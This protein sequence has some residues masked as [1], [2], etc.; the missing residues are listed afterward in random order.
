[1]AWVAPVLS[2]VGSLVGAFGAIQAGRT[3]NKAARFES[4]VLEQQSAREEQNAAAEARNYERRQRALL[5]S[6]RARRAGSG[7]DIGTGTSLLVDRDVVKEIELG[8]QTILNRGEVSS[9]RLDQQAALVRSGGKFAEYSG[10]VRGGTTLL[11]GFSG[12]EY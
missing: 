7:V 9:T 6:A 10:Y 12:I 2:V 3:Q 1:M 11:S 4:A 5:A 8:R